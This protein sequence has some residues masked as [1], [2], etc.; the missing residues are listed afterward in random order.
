MPV[1]KWDYTYYEHSEGNG[2]IKRLDEQTANM[3]EHER[4]EV[5]A[6]CEKIS[7]FPHA[8]TTTKSYMQL[9]DF[10]ENPLVVD[11]V[12]KLLSSWEVPEYCCMAIG[13]GDTKLDVVGYFYSVS[14]LSIAKVSRERNLTLLKDLTERFIHIRNTSLIR[15]MERNFAKLKGQFV[16]LEDLLDI[17]TSFEKEAAKIAKTREATKMLTAQ[18]ANVGKELKKD[19]KAYCEWLATLNKPPVHAFDSYR[20]YEFRFFSLDR[21]YALSDEVLAMLQTWN[22]NN[23]EKDP[24]GYFYSME[25]LNKNVFYKGVTIYKKY[26]DF[27]ISLLPKLIEQKDLFNTDIQECINNLAWKR[28]SWEKYHTEIQKGERAYHG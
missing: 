18:T 6:Y 22:I 8:P 16:D 17:I 21:T 5:W 3:P 23:L 7:S 28:E 26:L 25:L 11:A 4:D 10:A 12:Y 9:S 13:Y 24:V 20:V 1:K 14:L 2:A 19:I 15:L 27:L